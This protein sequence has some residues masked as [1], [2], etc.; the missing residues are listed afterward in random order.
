VKLTRPE[1]LHKKWELLLAV[2]DI[3]KK[4]VFKGDEEDAARYVGL[5]DSREKLFDQIKM[6]DEKIQGT[7]PCRE[8]ERISD[9]INKTAGEILALDKANEAEA[10]RIIGT[11]KKSLKDIKAGKSVSKT[12]T[13]FISTSEGMYF[14]TKN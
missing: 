9:E 3:T 2:Y 11:L 5:M 7:A 1:L 13:D 14:D 12:Y 6:L 8:A 10:S 4:T